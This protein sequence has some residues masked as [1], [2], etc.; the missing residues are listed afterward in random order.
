MTCQFMFYAFLIGF[1][2]FCIKSIV[3]VFLKKKGLKSSKKDKGV[4]NRTLS[5]TN[6][7]RHDLNLC[8]RWYNIKHNV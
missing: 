2:I 5:Q 3:R 6:S 8:F 7:I 1:L 4:L